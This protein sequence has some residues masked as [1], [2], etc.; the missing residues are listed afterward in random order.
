[1]TCFLYREVS[2]SRDLPKVAQESM[3]L[4]G[5]VMIIL[6]ASIGFTNYLV[7]EMVP[8]KILEMMKIYIHSKLLFLMVLNVFLLIV[9]CL[10]DIFS[11]LIVVVPLILP[12]AEQFG[13]NPIHLG[14]IFLVNLE[15]GYNTPPVGLNLFIGSFRFG[16]SIGQLCKATLPFTLILLVALVIVT[17]VPWLSLGL[18]EWLHIQ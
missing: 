13:V 8:M 11:A 18:I 10:M 9:G 12:I 6:A 2:I 16:R 14:I 3:V 15:I 17:Y 5:V 4:I 1:M 7:D